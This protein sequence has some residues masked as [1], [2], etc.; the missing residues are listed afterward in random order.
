M[1]PINHLGQ[2]IGDPVPGWEPR[3]RPPRTVME[4]Q[5]ARLEPLDPG[6]HA[7]ELFEAFAADREER[8]WTYLPYGPFETF[9]GY[10]AWM[11]EACLGDDPK[12]HAIIDRH[13]GRASG[14]ASYLRITP[15]VGVIEVGHI[16]LAPSLQR[17]PTATDAIFIMMRRVFDELGYRRFEWKCDA[18]NAASRRAAERL[19]FVFE[20]IFRQAT[21]YK[22]RNRDTAWYALLDHEWPQVRGVFERWLDPDN[23]DDAGVQRLALSSLM[24]GVREA[25]S[26]NER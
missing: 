25:G 14:V 17:T 1:S 13:T 12:F 18:L 26:T 9:D 6:A 22:G 24:T 10:A 3:P 5:W 16:C 2:P 8:I 15:V 19:G 20:G 11:A 23:F 4:G 7:A 21:I